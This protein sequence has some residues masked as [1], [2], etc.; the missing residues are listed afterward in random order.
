M[1]RFITLSSQY[2]A[3]TATHNKYLIPSATLIVSGI[4]MD[5]D[6]RKR[7]FRSWVRDRVEVP[8]YTIDD[9]IQ[10]APIVAV[11][12]SDMILGREKEVKKRHVRHLI[13]AEASTLGTMFLLKLALDT[14]RPNGASFSMPSGHT[15]YSFASAGVLYHSLKDDRP[16]WAYSGYAM[17]TFVGASRVLRDKHWISDVLVGAGIGILGSHLTYNFDIWDSKGDAHQDEGLGHTTIGLSPTGIA[18]AVRF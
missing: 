2:S 13:T 5:K 10:H 6:Q 15:A 3:D 4:Y 7:D 11:L 14:K 16:F 17:A 18:L 8:S 1:S 9:Y 12:V